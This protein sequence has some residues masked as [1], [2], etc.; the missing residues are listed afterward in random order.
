MNWYIRFT[1][2]AFVYTYKSR[3]HD[4]ASCLRVYT[5]PLLLIQSK[6]LFTDARPSHHIAPAH[7]LTSACVNH[8]YFI[9]T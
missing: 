1:I 5:F 2:V 8:A 3:H 4:S 7:A 9:F 6:S